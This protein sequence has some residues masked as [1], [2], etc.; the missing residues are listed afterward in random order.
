[1]K[2]IIKKLIVF[3]LGWLL[4]TITVATLSTVLMTSNIAIQVF[5]AVFIVLIFTIML[6]CGYINKN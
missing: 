5:V 6:L 2:T 4:M 1:M 3:L